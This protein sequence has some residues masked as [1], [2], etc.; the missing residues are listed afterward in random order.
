[1]GRK[2]YVYGYTIEEDKDKIT[3]HTHTVE[4]TK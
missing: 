3:Y 4:S 1:M 2:Q